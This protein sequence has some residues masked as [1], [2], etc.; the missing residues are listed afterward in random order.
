MLK[1][2]FGLLKLKATMKKIGVNNYTRPRPAN[3]FKA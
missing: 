3:A 2:P 1:F